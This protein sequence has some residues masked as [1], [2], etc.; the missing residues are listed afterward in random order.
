MTLFLDRDGVINHRIVDGYVTNYSQFVFN[1]GSLAALALLAQHFYPIVV[2]TNQQGIGKGLMTQTNLQQLHTQMIQAVA[3]A[4]GRI[5]AVYYC[6]HLAN[7]N[8]TC[9][10][11]A[12]GMALQAQQQFSNI[13]LADSI[14]VGD[15]VSDLLFGRAAGTKT[16][17]VTNNND[18]TLPPHFNV[19]WADEI[20][21]NLMAFAN[22]YGG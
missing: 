7:A 5:D 11:P 1:D 10:K 2:V 12:I 18:Q 19:L 22:Q 21:P 8:C 20:V 14:M 16:V 15:S 13:V 3:A 6:P 9:R 4:G 17:F